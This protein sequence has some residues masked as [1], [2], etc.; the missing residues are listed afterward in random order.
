MKVTL[1]TVPD[2]P[3]FVGRSDEVGCIWWMWLFVLRVCWKQSCWWH[4]V[5]W[6]INLFHYLDEFPIG[7][8]GIHI[9]MW[10][11]QGQQLL[12]WS[13]K[14]SDLLSKRVCVRS[15]MMATCS[16]Y[17]PKTRCSAQTPTIPVLRKVLAAYPQ[18]KDAQPEGDPPT[19]VISEGRGD[20]KHH[21]TD[22]SGQTI[23]FHQ[24]NF[25]EIKGFNFG[26]RSCEVAIIQPD[27]SNI[28]NWY[29]CFRK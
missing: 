17:L 16:H 11:R 21:Q 12:K 24:L 29:G 25:P 22:W 15:N 18:T 9:V 4:R 28:M 8:L 1:D 27:G 26:V 7:V 3:P 14:T 5:N 2:E 13:W 19:K 10:A 6:S 20:S 23:I